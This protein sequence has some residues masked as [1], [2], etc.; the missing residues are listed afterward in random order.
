MQ[1]KRKDGDRFL[2]KRLFLP[3]QIFVNSISGHKLGPTFG[4]YI[5]I[6]KVKSSASALFLHICLGKICN[7]NR[8]EWSPIRSVIIRVITKSDDRAAGV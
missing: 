5:L 7:G 2:S 1:I 8:T 6:V 3:Y 4:I